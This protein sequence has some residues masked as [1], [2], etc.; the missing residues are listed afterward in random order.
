MLILWEM[1]RKV[2]LTFRGIAGTFDYTACYHG[3]ENGLKQRRY[4]REKT[5]SVDIAPPFPIYYCCVISNSC[6]FG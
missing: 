6:Q 5:I 3:K 2:R 1:G 4:T